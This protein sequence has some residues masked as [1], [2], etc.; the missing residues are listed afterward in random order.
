M[1]RL[2]DEPP[3]ETFGSPLPVR[4]EAQR[5]SDTPGVGSALAVGDFDG[6]GAPDVARVAALE[7]PQLEVRLSGR[8]DPDPVS[9]P[10]AGVE[11]LLAA[12]L[13]NDGRLDLLGYGPEIAR[14]WRNNV[15]MP[16]EDAPEAP[17]GA[18]A[19]VFVDATAE[20]GLET[21]RGAAAAVID[22]DIEGDLD[23]LLA[24]K[25]VELLRNNLQGTLEAV[26]AKVL[27]EITGAVRDVAATDLDRDGDLDLVLAG[28]N[29]LRWLDNLRQGKFQDRSDAAGLSAGSAVESL[30]SA[31]LDADGFPEA[32]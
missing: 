2:R 5:W 3:V 30:V 25:Q 8:A 26:G 4:F 14:F 22:F 6:D 10:A 28:D 16:T 21:A 11:G 23:L 27:P 32:S 31:D 19:E 1:R 24:G 12:D 7:P 9:F 17:A 18:R 13:D 15:E 20:L 29:G